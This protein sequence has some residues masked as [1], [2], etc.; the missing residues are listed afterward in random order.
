MYTRE[1][2][3]DMMKEREEAGIAN[4]RRIVSHDMRLFGVWFHHAGFVA[5]EMK[6]QVSLLFHL[7][8][9]V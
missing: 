8:A 4:R 2:G 9:F 7:K 3:S 1:E 6:S 5:Y